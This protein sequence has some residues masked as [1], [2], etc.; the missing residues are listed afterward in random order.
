M[1]FCLVAL[2]AMVSADL[3][4][5]RGNLPVEIL[6]VE[7]NDDSLEQFRTN[8]FE[9]DR[10]EEIEV[11]V[12]FRLNAGVTG[13]DQTYENVQVEAFMRGHDHRADTVQ[14]L[15]DTFTVK[16]GVVYDEELT[17]SIPSR[18]E[19][20]KFDLYVRVTTRNDG[21]A[22]VH[23]VM[24]VDAKEHEIRIKDIVLNPE[25]EVKA[26]RTLLVALRLKNM[27]KKDEEGV[28]VRA[29]IPEL[30]VSASDFVN[31]IEAEETNNNAND[32]DQATSNELFLRIPSDAPTGEYTLVAEAHF[33]DLDEVVREETTV[34]VV[35]VEQTA[36]PVAQK[37]ERTVIFVPTE[38]Q[39]LTAGGSE[40]F[41]PIAIS[42]E[43]SEAK[44]YIV[45]VDSLAWGTAKVSPSSL[46]VVE[47][48][49]SKNV[50]V[51][52][53]ANAN[54]PTGEQ[55]FLVTV[56]EGNDVLQQIPLE[57][58]ISGAEEA[59]SE[60]FKLRTVLEVLAVVLLV[61]VIIILLV[62]G[63]SRVMR[64]DDEDAEETETYY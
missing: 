10:G 13:G 35:G 47:A 29:Y 54:A 50:N 30:G 15:S 57:A 9:L 23:Y 27:G 49:D 53:K 56:K 28:K 24:E 32:N 52:V 46:V 37:E 34:R 51:H 3:E 21:Y 17:L 60:G 61:L 8:D 44:S 11:N 58:T 25:N 26:G 6:D 36:A 18:L 16:P 22:E 40:M 33:R 5:Q 55:L 45:S 31:E 64:R 63:M 42:N 2:S 38:M 43:G 7:V 48:G 12:R 41:Y 59:G 62:F 4:N 14:D 39:A 1:V 20:D 19:Q